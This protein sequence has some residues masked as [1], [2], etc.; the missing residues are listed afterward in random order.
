FQK[1][2]RAGEPIS[3]SELL[4]PLMRAYD[5]VA[6][7]ADVE[8]GGTDQLYNLLAGRDVMEAY[9]V[10]P[11]VVLTTPLLL[12]WDGEKM[13]SSLG[14]NIPLTM[15]PEEQF[16]RTMRI[17]D[18]LLPQWY[19]LVMEREAPAGDS[20]EAKLALARFIVARSHGEEAAR[21]AE[22]HFSRVVREGRPPEDVPEV[23][24]P[25]E[26]PVHLPRVLS[27]QL[28]ITTSQ[29]RRLIDQGGVRLN[30]EPVAELDV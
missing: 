19:G 16:G 25:A 24:L 18:E 27:R 3:V 15:A 22:D 2:Y 7:E 26:D 14:N 11:Q 4:Y 13:S 20:L 17:P 30:G 8:L 5:S 10:E 21:R 6:I 9:G 29:A 1:R 28:G 12:S 23:A